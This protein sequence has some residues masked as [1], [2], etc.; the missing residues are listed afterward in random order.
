[1]QKNKSRAEWNKFYDNGTIDVDPGE[2]AV[3]TKGAL[4]RGIGYWNLMY[5]QA[6][7]RRVRL[8]R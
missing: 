1:M 6:R 2:G 8:R 5:E 3:F 4:L 7:L